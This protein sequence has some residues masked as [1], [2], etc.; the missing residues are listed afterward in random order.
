MRDKLTT[1]R[2][3]LHLIPVHSPWYHIEIDFIGPLSPVS[4]SGNQYILMISNYFTKWI[5]AAA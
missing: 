2:P 4:Q 3:E 5:A 1:T